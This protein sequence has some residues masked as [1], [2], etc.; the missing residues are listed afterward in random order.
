MAETFDV[1]PGIELPIREVA[2]RLA[3]MWETDSP[4]SLMAFHASQMNVIMHLG[5]STDLEDA[6][7]RF[8]ALIRFAQRYPCRIIVLCPTHSK[9]EN[10][11][12]SKLFSQCYIGKSHREM[13]CCEALILKYNPMDSEHLFNQVSIWLEGDL[14]TYYW[15]SGVSVQHIK[16]CLDEI[17]KLGVRRCVFDSSVNSSELAALDWPE[18]R[19][20]G[21]LTEARL[22]PMRQIIGQ[23]LSQYPIE[24]LLKRLKSVKVLYAGV[25]AEARSLLEWVKACLSDRRKHDTL[26]TEFLLEDAESESSYLLELKFL[27][28]DKSYFNCSRL[29]DSLRCVL[30]ADFGEGTELVHVPIKPLAEEQLLAEAFFRK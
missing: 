8:D 25:S 1:L 23:F 11:M 28:E 4:D 24:T 6:H 29:K 18:E 21:D 30:K 10:G 16:N 2:D 26:E 12:E 22:L 7:A 19:K 15:F 27:Y 17:L 3:S 14:P 9:L 20:L 5:L 13:C